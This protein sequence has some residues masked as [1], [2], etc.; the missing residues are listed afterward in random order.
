MVASMCVLLHTALLVALGLAEYAW[1]CTMS[2]DGAPPA[3]LVVLAAP[4]VL[5]RMLLLLGVS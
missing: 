5:V 1:W 3:P 4:V 2:P